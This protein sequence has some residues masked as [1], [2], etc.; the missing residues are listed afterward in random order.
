MFQ[1]IMTFVFL[2]GIVGL[3]VLDHD[4]KAQTSMALWIAVA[5]LFINCSRP[6][7]Y[8]MAMFHLAGAAPDTGEG[9]LE[10]SPLDATVFMFLLIAGIVVLAARSERV[11]P[12]VR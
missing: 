3:F 5:W 11:T 4:K 1:L 10:G 6:V 8:W 12:L 9:Y 2:A 7:S